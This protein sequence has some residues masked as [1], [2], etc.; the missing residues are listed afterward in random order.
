MKAER[1]ADQRTVRVEHSPFGMQAGE[2]HTAL[3]AK[4]TRAES[5]SIFRPGSLQTETRRLSTHSPG[6]QLPSELKIAPE[7]ITKKSDKIGI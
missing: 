5:R 7:G 1:S 4:M 2:A 3:T 6:H